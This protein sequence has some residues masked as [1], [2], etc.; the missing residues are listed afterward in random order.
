MGS[1]LPKFLTYF[2]AY[3]QSKSFAF[4][5]KIF[6]MLKYQSIFKGLK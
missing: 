1:E 2:Y 5:M 6:L 3:R 4:Y